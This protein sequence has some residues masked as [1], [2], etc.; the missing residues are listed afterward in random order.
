M[1][2]VRWSLVALVAAACAG[3]AQSAPSRS[4]SPAS[5]T[6]SGGA[7]TRVD[8]TAQSATATAL[9]LTDGTVIQITAATRTIRTDRATLADLKTGQ[10]VAITAKQ[11]PDGTLLAT[12]VNVFP[13]SIGANIPAG[14]RPLTEG[15]LMTNAPIAA[16]DQVSGSSFTVTFSGN[17]VKVVLASNAVITAQT[18]VKPTDIPV[19]TKIS[20]T[21]R[22]GVAQGIQFQGP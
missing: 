21:V 11:Q 4:P 8:G 5:A 9:T 17:T 7:A 20:A 2:I 6:A 12:I 13:A 15:N 18:D 10:F 3:A 19:G 16:I 14:Q 22:A 1:R